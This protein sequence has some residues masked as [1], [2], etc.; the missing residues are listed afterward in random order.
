MPSF[1]ASRCWW[2]L[3]LSR[4]Q[5]SKCD[6]SRGCY[7]SGWIILAD[8]YLQ[9]DLL[10]Q[11]IRHLDFHRTLVPLL[12]IRINLSVENYLST[13]SEP[14]PDAVESHLR[15]MYGNSAHLVSYVHK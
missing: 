10:S 15:R 14:E 11:N 6:K 12:V 7:L 2:L 8:L 1:V 5:Y 4:T 13:G 3:A 9:Y